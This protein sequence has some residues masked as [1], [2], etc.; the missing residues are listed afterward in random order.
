MGKASNVPPALQAR[1]DAQDKLKTAAS[2]NT[3]ANDSPWSYGTTSGRKI[4]TSGT[5][6]KGSRS[7]QMTLARATANTARNLKRTNDEKRATADNA[8]RS[9]HAIMEDKNFNRR[10]DWGRRGAGRTVLMPFIMSA[11]IAAAIAVLFMT[12]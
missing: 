8:S 12:E 5:Q 3:A 9:R 11:L 7:A 2:D 6:S 1:W 10:H 4:K